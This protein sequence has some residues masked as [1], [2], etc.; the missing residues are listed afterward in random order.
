VRKECGIIILSLGLSWQAG[1]EG[2]REDAQEG[3]LDGIGG[4][5][6]SPTCKAVPVIKAMNRF[7]SFAVVGDARGLHRRR[8]TQKFGT[9][10]EGCG[11]AL[12]Q[13]GI[14]DCARLDL[15][16][17]QDRRVPTG[18]GVHGEYL[19]GVRRRCS[20]TNDEDVAR[21]FRKSRKWF[22]WTKDT[23]ESVRDSLI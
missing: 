4:F 11:Q 16:L 21:H 9:E 1:P 13:D 20:R 7:F 10:V 8:S 18:E 17:W 5:V 19:E 12:P 3:F 2:V 22:L 14:R 23:N 6:V 15:C